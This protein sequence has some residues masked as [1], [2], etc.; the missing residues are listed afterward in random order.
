MWYWNLGGEIKFNPILLYRARGL[1]I[2]QNCALPE[3]E[4]PNYVLSSAV[5]SLTKARKRYM[6]ITGEEGHGK[7]I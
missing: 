1:K 2:G 4:Q 5:V 6:A 3:N 7:Y